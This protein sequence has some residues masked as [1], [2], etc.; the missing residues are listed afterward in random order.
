MRSRRFACR[1]RRAR[2]AH[3]EELARVGIPDAF[4]GACRFARNPALV[5][6][7][8][9]ARH[10]VASGVMPDVKTV[11][12]HYLVRGKPGFVEHRWAAL[13]ER[14]AGSAPPAASRWSP[15]RRATGCPLALGELFDRFVAAGGEA[16]EVVAGAH[17]EDEMRRFAS[18]ARQRGLL[19]SRASDF[20]GVQESMVDVGRCN[21]LPADLEPVWS[22]LPAT[23]AA[24]AAA[25]SSVR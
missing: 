20:H 19:A 21:P 23:A 8:H 24:L 11:F 2:A 3:G 25:A 18:L 4:A 16:V 10:L 22:R 5:S 15:I 7:A 6:R 14:W 17:T 9:F 13:E 12:D 1:T